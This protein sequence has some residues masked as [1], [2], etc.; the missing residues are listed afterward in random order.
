MRYCLLLFAAAVA[1]LVLA[2]PAHATIWTY[3][4]LLD[5]LQETPPNTS[6]A[7]GSATVLIDDVLSTM[8]VSGTYSGLL[9][10][11]TAAHVHGLAG[12]GVPAGVIFPLTIGG[13]L[14]SGGASLTPSQLAGALG[15]LT[16]INIHTTLYPGGEIR[17]QIVPEPGLALWLGIG[18]LA[19]LRRR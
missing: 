8:S 4:A 15:G 19:L 16:Y 12:P 1:C 11:V 18:A 6:P 7:T 3:S 2:P 5:G 14:F 9:G 13:G 10:S 17:G